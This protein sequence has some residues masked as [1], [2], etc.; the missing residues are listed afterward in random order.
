MAQVFPMCFAIQMSND[1]IDGHTHFL[2]IK[3][4]K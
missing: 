4:I 3:V 1:K 2:N